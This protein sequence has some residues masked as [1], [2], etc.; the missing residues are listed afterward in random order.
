MTTAVDH[1]LA[2]VL[3]VVA[4]LNAWRDGRRFVRAVE[5]GDDLD[6]GS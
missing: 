1:A 6:V 4:P 5:S 2:F 3:V